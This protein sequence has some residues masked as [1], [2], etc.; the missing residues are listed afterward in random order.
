MRLIDVSRPPWEVIRQIGRCRIVLSQSL[1]GLIVADAFN[2]P[3]LWIAPAQHMQGGDYKFMDYFS[4]LDAPKQSHPMTRELL[5]AG[6][7][8]EASVGIYRGNKA[9]Y[10]EILASALRQGL[11]P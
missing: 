11:A 10:H 8:P 1:H 9:E 7:W 6:S 3:N 4:T 5:C 2:I